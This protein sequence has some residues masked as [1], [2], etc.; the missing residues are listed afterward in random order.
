MSALN[1]CDDVSAA[2]A[3]LKALEQSPPS[4]AREEELLALNQELRKLRKLVCD[5][6]NAIHGWNKEKKQL[7]GLRKQVDRALSNWEYQTEVDISDKRLKEVEKELSTGGL[8]DSK[9][10]KLQKER[11]RILA[12][13]SKA[14]EEARVTSAAESTAPATKSAA[15]K[16]AEYEA[17]LAQAL[18]SRTAQS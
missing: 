17:H 6:M 16:I 9:R 13:R 15:E 5:R 3:R 4:T 18:R 11:R 1:L 14:S 8:N 2:L 12:L 7:Q 10:R